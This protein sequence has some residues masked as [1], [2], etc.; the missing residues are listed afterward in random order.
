MEDKNLTMARQVAEQVAQAGGRTYYVGGLVRD[1]LLGRESKDVDIE[2][3]GITPEKLEAILEDLGTPI[4]M[5]ASFGVYGLAHYELD[6][7]MPRKARLIGGK[8]DFASSVEPF[9]GTREAARRR[10]LTFNAMMQDVLTGEILD[11]FGGRE[12]L[13]A[14]VIRHVDDDTFAE[15]PLRVLRAAQLAARF[16][17]TICPETIELCACLPLRQIARERVYLEL[18]KALLKTEKPSV[19]FEALGRMHQ[20]SCWF[21]E[22]EA[23]IGVEQ[24]PRFHPEG[25]VWNHTMEVID[26]AAMLREQAQNPLGL[27]LAALCHDFGKVSTTAVIDGRIRALGHEEAGVPLGMRFLSRLTD[28]R[29]LSKYVSNMI[30][31]HMRPNLLAAQNSGWKAYCRLYDLSECPED[32]ILLSVADRGG[33]EDYVPCLQ[34]E[35]AVYRELMARPCVTGADLIAMGFQPGPRFK[36]ALAFSHKLHLSGVDKEAALK[37][38]VQMLKSSK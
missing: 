8:D 9:L 25:D 4:L 17:F 36:E 28:D 34:K 1:W 22:L 32:L 35:L 15:D 13:A 38:T 21:P 26:R 6:I 20:L 14:G 19:F 24:E 18:Q 27:M 30:L 16:R 5:G 7:S 10:D 11:A 29:R 3:H 37:Q 23:L 33:K 12:D 2:I 31:L